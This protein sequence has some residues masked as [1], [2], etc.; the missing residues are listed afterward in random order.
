MP[1][2]SAQYYLFFLAVFFIA[3]G[4]NGFVRLRTW[5]ILFL[6]LFFYF[7]TNGLQVVILLAVSTIDYFVCRI[8]EREENQTR[9]KLLVLVS[10]CSNLGILGYFKYFNFF[11]AEILSWAH[12]LGY[13][14]SWVTINVALPVGISFFTFEA[15]S[16]T[17]DVYRKVIPAERR[18]SRLMFLVAFFPHLI[19]G[20]IVRA[21][22]FFP[23]IASPRKLTADRF[24]FGLYL[25]IHGL[26]KK[27]VLADTLAA[28]VDA[29]FSNPAEVGTIGAWVGVY[30]FAFQIYFDF[31]GYTDVAL[32][33]AALLGYDLPRNFRQPYAAWCITDFWR[34]WH[35]SLSTWLRDYLYISLGG[36]RTRSRIGVYR[37]LMVT[38]L[39][40]GLW[41]GA[42]W[43]FVIWGGL[44]GALL[45]IERA[46]KIRSREQEFDRMSAWKRSM[47]RFTAFN[48]IVL[49]W[50]PFRA[51]SV[52]SALSL[53]TT[54]FALS[55]GT[56][57]VAGH[58]VVICVV[59]WGWA[60]Q[61]I[62]NDDDLRARLLGLPVLFK[63]ACYGAT[64][65]LIS[66]FSSQGSI[67][68]IYF[69][70]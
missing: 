45:C 55:A 42:A 67:P 69:Q 61:L 31:S 28:F 25:F 9:R 44:H 34:R 53:L 66:V 29:A 48:V 10:I 46:L 51:S 1:F 65:V 30:A 56:K 8:M 27:V 41:H 26:F 13:Q 33:S 12:H 39:L 14:P 5:V 11:Q 4:L 3:A 37:N 58:I 64:L 21:S 63:Y 7:S 36:S 16:Y 60:W 23:Q 6:S 57:F 70:F 19:A 20:P 54:M 35:I 17:I 40:G 2:N 22:N 49:T 24:E 52:E 32:G 62:D 47:I 43:N 59:M 68:F 15:L 50:I 38:M 18:W